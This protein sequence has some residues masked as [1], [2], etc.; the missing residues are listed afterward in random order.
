MNLFVHNK[1]HQSL[2]DEAESFQDKIRRLICYVKFLKEIHK[3]FFM[4]GISQIP[5]RALASSVFCL[6]VCMWAF[7]FYL[8]FLCIDVMFLTRNFKGQI[9]VAV[10]MD[11]NHQFLSI[12][13]TFV[14]NE[15]NDNWY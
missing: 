11:G 9:L 3:V 12:A 14:K 7:Q 10:G 6:G 1:L 15:N 13:F 4:R 2:E 8:I 5:W